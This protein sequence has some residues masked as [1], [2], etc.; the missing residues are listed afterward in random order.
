MT[1]KNVFK[2]CIKWKKWYLHRVKISRHP[3]V[4]KNSSQRYISLDSNNFRQDLLYKNLPSACKLDRLLKTATNLWWKWKILFSL[5]NTY[6]LVWFVCRETVSDMSVL[7]NSYCVNDLSYREVLKKS[8]GYNSF[9][10]DENKTLMS[11]LC[12]KLGIAEVRYATW[13]LPAFENHF[14]FRLCFN[15][16]S[17][18]K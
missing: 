15:E 10:Y 6:F 2:C 7:C 4:H 9:G 11:L 13:C 14:S 1:Y 18:K 16:C 8:F 5:N 17:K 12:W 3:W